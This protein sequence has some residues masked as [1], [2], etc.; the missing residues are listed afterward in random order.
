MKIA[1][2]TNPNKDTYWTVVTGPGFGAEEGKTFIDV[3][4]INGLKSAS[5]SFQSYMTEKLSDMG[6]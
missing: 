5:F 6:V 2:R 4:A 1:F 3:K